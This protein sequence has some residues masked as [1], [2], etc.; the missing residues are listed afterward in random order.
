MEGIDIDVPSFYICPISLEIMRDPVIVSTGI[1]YDRDS[2]EK[3]MSSNTKN[4]FCPVTKLPISDI[5]LTPNHTLR[6]LIQSWCTENSSRGIERIPTPKAPISRAQISEILRKGAASPVAQSKG[7]RRLKSI[8]SN[9]ANRRSIEAAGGADFLAEIICSTSPSSP[10]EDLS[11]MDSLLD[12]KSPREEALSI[13]YNLQLSNAGLKALVGRKDGEFIE[14][15]TRVMQRGSYESRAYAVML[16]NSMFEVADPIQMITLISRDFFIQ[17]VQILHD[18]ISPHSSKDALKLLIQIVLWGRNRIKAVEAGLVPVLVG[19]L[20]DCSASDGGRR[21]VEM[22]LML[23]EMICQTAEGRAELLKHGAGLAVVSKKILRVSQVASERAV[24]ILL[25]V[26]KH[27]ATPAVLQEML[28]LGI[29]A[30]LCLVLQ[31]E[32]GSKTKEKAKEILKLHAR[33]WKNSPCIPMN[34]HSSYPS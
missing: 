19:L 22:S 30:K 28:Q 15:L 20:L 11:D 13:L 25:S 24:R 27:S 31:V 1:T 6:R 26:S 29:V 2:I 18:Q 12:V 16:L 33:A 8:A 3:W 10:L 17:V 4:S 34:L 14:S 5:E 21:L 32:C 23:L 9:N 7:L